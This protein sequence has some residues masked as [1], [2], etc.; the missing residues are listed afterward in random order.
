M[1]VKK[2]KLELYMEQLTGS[3]LKNEFNKAGYWYSIY[4]TY[5]QSTSCEI[6][7]WMSYKLQPSLLREIPTTSVMQII[8]LN[9]GKQEE[10][11]NLLM[12]VKEESEKAGLKLN[13]QKLR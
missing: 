13:I 12:R 11:K 6:L 2:Q 7:D 9:G 10:L 8:Q 5:T 1:W 3:Q 4:L